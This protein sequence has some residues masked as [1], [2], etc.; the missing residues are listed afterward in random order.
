MRIKAYCYNKTEKFI[1]NY[2]IYNDMKTTIQINQNTLELLK[3]VRDDTSSNSYDEAI[4]KIIIRNL[5]KE[6]LFGYL[7]KKNRKFILR[8][9][10]EKSDRF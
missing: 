9:L 4:N 2:I 1:Y 6:S 5:N 7:G 3:K 10:R 8:G